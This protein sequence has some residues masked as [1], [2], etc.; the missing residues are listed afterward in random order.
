MNK[1][2][3]REMHGKQEAIKSFLLRA[4]ARGEQVDRETFVGG[5][6]FFWRNNNNSNNSYEGGKE[7]KQKIA[8]GF[9]SKVNLTLGLAYEMASLYTEAKK[10]EK[11]VPEAVKTLT[12]SV[13][14]KVKMEELKKKLGEFDTAG[15]NT[16]RK[17]GIERYLN[18]V[19]A[20]RGVL[21]LLDREARR[22]QEKGENVHGRPVAPF[23]PAFKVALETLH[24]TSK[25][26]NGVYPTISHSMYLRIESA[27]KSGRHYQVAMELAATV[28][29][30]WRKPFEVKDVAPATPVPET[31]PEESAK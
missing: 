2:M 10:K 23:A 7:M 26:T 5:R 16:V 15:F 18:G 21:T 11:E 17:V 27:L 9:F 1:G 24:N 28:P 31:R 29:E 25:E 13:E 8:T 12:A 22:R 6:K 4:E 19:I 20:E 3:V 30:K 14:Y